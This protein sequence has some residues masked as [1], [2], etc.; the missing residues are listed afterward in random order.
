ME[1]NI[2]DAERDRGLA[3]EHSA[4]EGD[5]DRARYSMMVRCASQSSLDESSQ[6]REAGEGAG[7]QHAAQ[8]LDALARL[9]RDD[10]LCD[11][12]LQVPPGQ[13]HPTCSYCFF[14]IKL[15]HG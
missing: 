13:A 15:N 2:G 3:V 9:R 1:G 5:G 6:R 14:F 12:R 7:A 8:L 10:V 11:V 4:A